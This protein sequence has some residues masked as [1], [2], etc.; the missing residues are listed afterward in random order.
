MYVAIFKCILI[1]C[2]ILLYVHKQGFFEEELYYLN[3]I[4][5]CVFLRSYWLDSMDADG[6]DNAILRPSI[7]VFGIWGRGS[8]VA[9]CKCCISIY[10]FFKNKY[11][12]K[13]H[14]ATLAPRLSY[15]QL[16]AV[17]HDQTLTLC[18][19]RLRCGPLVAELMVKMLKV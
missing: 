3:E 17:Q 14:T 1:A 2:S 19:A 13:R 9:E 6:R 8:S 12:N 4:D 18:D 7:W 11:T 15:L 16:A 5:V 10:Q